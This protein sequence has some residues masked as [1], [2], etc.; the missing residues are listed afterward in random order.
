MEQTSDY[1]A[2][3]KRWEELHRTRTYARLDSMPLCESVIAHLRPM[4]K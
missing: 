3:L 2:A 1:E 4:N